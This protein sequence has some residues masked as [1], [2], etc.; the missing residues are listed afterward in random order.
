MEVAHRCPKSPRTAAEKLWA[1]WRWLMLLLL[2]IAPIVQ[3]VATF[4]LEKL[5]PSFNPGVSPVRWEKS[6]K[7]SACF[8]EEGS[9]TT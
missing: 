1:G 7:I 4:M 3:A 5:V 2:L 6:L 8:G 9:L